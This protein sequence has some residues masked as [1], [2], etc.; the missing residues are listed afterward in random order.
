MRPITYYWLMS[1]TSFPLID[2]NQ[3][4][5][6]RQ[7][8]YNGARVSRV[9]P[10]DS[11]DVSITGMDSIHNAQD[12]INAYMNLKDLNGKL[13]DTVSDLCKTLHEKD[14]VMRG[15]NMQIKTKGRFIPCPPNCGH[16]H[17]TVDTH[18][19]MGNKV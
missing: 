1:K 3:T 12:L 7:S 13:R 2:G 4:I 18:D 16:N 5:Y 6:D 9:I 11:K 8:P 14:L 19:E 10:I 17:G 15:L